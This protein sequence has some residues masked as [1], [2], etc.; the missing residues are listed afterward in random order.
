[1]E[2]TFSSNNSN[3]FH[4][5]QCPIHIREFSMVSWSCNFLIGNCNIE[6]L[7]EEDFIEFDK[8]LIE[9]NQSYFDLT[10]DGFNEWFES[11]LNELN[12]QSEIDGGGRWSFISNEKFEIKSC[13]YY[14]SQVLGL[15]YLKNL[16]LQSR[17]INKRNIIQVMATGYKMGSS[18]W[19]GQS[20]CGN[21]VIVNNQRLSLCFRVFNTFQICHV[22]SFNNREF[23][24]ENH[25]SALNNLMIWITDENSKPIRFTNPV[26]VYLSVQPINEDVISGEPFQDL[27]PNIE[28]KEKI[29][30]KARE[31]HEKKEKGLINLANFDKTA[32]R[33]NEDLEFPLKSIVE[34]D[35]ELRNLKET[36]RR[37]NPDREREIKE[38][39][40]NYKKE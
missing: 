9:I 31:I 18:M 21:E 39:E 1:M 28:L 16:P 10:K 30:N 33:K 6:V 19:L 2:Y 12:I 23:K 22:F 5:I 26:Y 17:E 3:N 38:L 37:K 29:K 40:E 20:N 8:G 7:N 24:I 34:E 15:Y 32:D 13:S 11:K 4:L 14:L 25:S 27:P 36:T 35:L